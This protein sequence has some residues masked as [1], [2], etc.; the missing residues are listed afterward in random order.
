MG[1][2]LFAVVRVLRLVPSVG[3]FFSFLGA[4]A[5]LGAAFFVLLLASLS[6]SSDF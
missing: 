1:E 6:F 2:F 4:A 5:F 3:S